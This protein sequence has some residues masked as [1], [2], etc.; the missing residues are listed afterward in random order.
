MDTNV[1]PTW[2][3]LL[4]QLP[5]KPD[6]LRVKL[7]RR[8]QKLGAASIK[9]G[10]YALPLS[11]ANSKASERLRAE[12]T[13]DKGDLIV[14][15]AVLLAGLTDQELAQRFESSAVAPPENPS[16]QTWVT[17][18]DVFVDRMGCAW[19]IRKFID[20]DAR[21]RFI[22]ARGRVRPS[23]LGYDMPGGAFAHHGD[24]CTFEALV[25]HYRLNGPAIDAIAEIIHDIDLQDDK[26]G[27]AEAPGVFVML[28]GIRESEASDD[29][30]VARAGDLFDALY[31][32]FSNAARAR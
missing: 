18:A 21:F 31:A 11:D 23:E 3:L 5:A 1:S 29:K 26:F 32:Q 12:L 20:P 30:R 8:L 6:Y 24:R 4:P 22:D 2:L 25:D 17:R 16:G 27:R 13:G 7:Q 10:V 9:N 19:L 14:L 15:G 28:K